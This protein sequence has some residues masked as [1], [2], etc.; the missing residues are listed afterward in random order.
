MN[1]ICG[2]SKLV[3]SEIP[4]L[5]IFPPEKRSLIGRLLRYLSTEARKTNIMPTGI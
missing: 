1:A 3:A 4:P 2:V 5:I